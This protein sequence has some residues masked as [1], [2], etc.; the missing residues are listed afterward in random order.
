MSYDQ[1]CYDL[2]YEFLRYNPDI[3]DHGHVSELAQLIQTTI[4]DHIA[5]EQKAWDEANAQFGVGA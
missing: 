5:S 3:H 4:E 2:A 1:K